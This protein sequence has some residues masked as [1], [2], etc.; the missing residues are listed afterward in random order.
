VII[1]IHFVADL[2]FCSD[3]QKAARYF[4]DADCYFLERNRY[5]SLG[6]H[7]AW[8]YSDEHWLI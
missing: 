2:C 7:G 1:W 3:G 4:L 6:S 8:M 5:V